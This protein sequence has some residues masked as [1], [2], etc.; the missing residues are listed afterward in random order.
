MDDLRTTNEKI[1]ERVGSRHA[2]YGSLR[3]G[4]YNARREDET[5]KRIGEVTITGFKMY[6][7]Y[8]GAYPCIVRTDNKKDTVVVELF[9]ITDENRILGIYGMEI[10]AGYH[11]E[12]VDVNG[13]T[14]GI[15]VYPEGYKNTV[16][17][18]SGDWVKFKSQKSATVS[19]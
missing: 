15:Y 14:C 6:S 11:L 7:L 10:G 19:H 1:V 18:L 16:P 5:Y 2:F 13:E 17:V 9:N 12:H 3:N 4:Q 8:G